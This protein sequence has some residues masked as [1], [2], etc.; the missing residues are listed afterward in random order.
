MAVADHAR[1]AH[2]AG[3]SDRELGND[4]RVAMK[5]PVADHTADAVI[6]IDAGR[7]A[8]VDRDR[9]QLGGHQPAALPRQLPA[10]RGIE[11]VLAADGAH[12]RQHGE[13]FAE[14]LHA[15]TLVIDGHQQWRCARGADLGDQ[16]F[17]LLDALEIAREQDH[18]ADE[19]MLQQVA[20]LVAERRA[21]HV[22]HQRTECHGA[23]RYLA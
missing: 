5:R 13:I 12:R 21:L 18:R 1:L 17:E 7:E 15:P 16:T 8:H 2:A 6:E 4:L 22:D 11:I 3:E 23:S 10:G 20:I 19:R 9:A 14:A